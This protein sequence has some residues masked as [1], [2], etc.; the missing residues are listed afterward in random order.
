M[1]RYDL[2]LRGGSAVFAEE[3]KIRRC[4]I[5]IK[6]GKIAAIGDFDSDCAKREID[7]SGNY[8]AP[9]FMDA[10][11]HIESSLLSP[12]EFAKTVLPHGTTC[13]IADPHELVNVGGAAAL[14]AFLDMASAACID[15]FTA[16]PSSVPATPFDTNGAGEFSASDMQKYAHRSDVCGLGE[17][18]CYDEVLKGDRAVF[19]KIKL[20]EHKTVDG[21]TAGLDADNLRKYA[22]AGIGNDHECVSFDDAELRLGC[23]LNVYIREGSAAHNTKDIVEGIL[24]KRERKLEKYVEYIAHVAFCSDDKHLSTIEK[25]GHISENVRIALR[26]GLPLADA[27]RIASYNPAR[28]YNM[29]ERGDIAVGMIADL[30]VL[31]DSLATDIL[32]VIKDGETA[33]EKG[34]IRDFS[35]LN[36]TKDVTKHR[37]LQN[38]VNYKHFSESDFDVKFKIGDAA[39]SLVARQLIT[40]KVIL[41]GK[42]A[43]KANILVTVERYGKNGNKALC[44][45]LGYGICGG[46][47]ATSFSHD[48]HN[49]VAAG[50][51]AR[52]IALALNRLREIGGGYV[53]V[54]G[55]RV[56][57]ELS[58]DAGGLVS[59]ESAQYVQ[60]RLNVLETAVKALG[61]NP[62]IDAFATLSFVALPVIPQVRLLD[63]GLFDVTERRFIK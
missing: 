39:I 35:R 44:P 11:V 9:S 5:G 10:H 43:E 63:T 62:D 32:Y 59:S 56:S 24:S 45:L 48:S 58:L 40:E 28:F 12:G 37:F 18:M 42:Q 3:G 15:I 51:N 27:V 31:S 19:D 57:A 8:V 55:G 36:N 13:V 53:L 22:S 21:H 34:T 33:A 14:D 30:V 20:F 52:D 6:D 16:V 49:A 1:E 60:S 2:V 46:A 26:C 61:V 23:G 41:D 47:L 38:S 7:C 25:K 54:A 4:D 17:V 29:P 50:D